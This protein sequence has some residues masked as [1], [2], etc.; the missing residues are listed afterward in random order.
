MFDEIFDTSIEVGGEILLAGV[1]TSPFW[2]H[3][4]QG[5]FFWL[6]AITDVV[7]G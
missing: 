7:E 5:K 2:W 4:G 3:R 6:E 1:D